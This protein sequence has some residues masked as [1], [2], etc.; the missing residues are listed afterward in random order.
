MNYIDFTIAVSIFL[1]FFALVLMFSTN[2]F[3]NISGLTKTSEFRSVTEGL[4]NLFFSGK[5]IPE[6]WENLNIVPVQLGFIE[7]L[8]RIP[9]L[10]KENSGYNLTNEI[11]SVDLIFDADCGNKAW[12]SSVRVFD[13]EGN[14]FPFKIINE[15]L[16]SNQFL[17]NARIIWLTN[18]SSNQNKKFYVYYSSENIINQNYS[19]SYNSSS[20]IPNNGDDWTENNAND[21]VCTRMSCYNSADS[22]LRYYSVVADCDDYTSGWYGIEYNPTVLL[23]LSDYKK[24][25]FWFKSNT[26]DSIELQLFTDSNNKYTRNITPTTYWILYEFDVGPDSSGWNE[27]GSPS[28]E[29]ID[30]FG[31]N[32]TNSVAISFWVDGFHFKKIPVE[33]KTFP[34]ED[35]SSISS[36]KI[37]ALKNL[38]YDEMIKTLS[39]YKFRI[40]ISE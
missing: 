17:K 37:N 24:L 18:I 36:S 32:S 31:F 19:I 2:Y 8:H 4:F 21:W 23:N 39:G 38:N 12:N 28:W 27:Y 9:I 15:T 25:E 20:W 16:C 34:E 30:H 35:L 6:N 1:F 29:N 33:V 11:V 40:E 22:K 3:S 5:G 10:I 7:D 13:Y 26:T 14:N